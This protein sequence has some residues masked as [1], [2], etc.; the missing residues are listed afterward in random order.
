VGEPINLLKNVKIAGGGGGE[1]FPGGMKAALGCGKQ[2]Q[3]AELSLVV[4]FHFSIWT[5]KDKQEHKTATT[6][7]EGAVGT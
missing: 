6:G 3:K 4:S 7:R 1:T 5:V 2:K